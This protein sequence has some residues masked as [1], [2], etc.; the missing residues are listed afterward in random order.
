MLRMHKRAASYSVLIS[1]TPYLW[2]FGIQLLFNSL[3]SPDS[4]LLARYGILCVS[5]RF[6]RRIRIRMRIVKH[7]KKGL[8]VRSPL[9]ALTVAAD[10]LSRFSGQAQKSIF[11]NT[12]KEAE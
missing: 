5:L 9:Q 10:A 1:L 4:V 8:R 7:L 3:H 12:R 2:S 11:S 6:F